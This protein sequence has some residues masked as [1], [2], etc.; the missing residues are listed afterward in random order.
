M[1]EG[2]HNYHHA[3]PW[4]YRNGVA[5]MS[6]DPTKW[7]ICLFSWISLTKNLTR[8]PAEAIAEKRKGLAAA[9]RVA[10]E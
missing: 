3:F 8:A 6:Y 4:D 1:G 10:L 7:L 2:Y 9:V 5:L